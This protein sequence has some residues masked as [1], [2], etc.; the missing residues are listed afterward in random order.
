MFSYAECSVIQSAIH[1][2]QLC[3]VLN[4][5]VCLA[6]QF[7]QLFNGVQLNSVLRYSVCSAF[8]C[9]QLSSVFSYPVS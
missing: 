8:E 9:V 3:I 7:L 6:I 5:P 2:G 1:F 4:Y